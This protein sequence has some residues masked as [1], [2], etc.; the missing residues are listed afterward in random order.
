M[1]DN[2]EPDLSIRLLLKV[3]DQ[4]YDKKSWHGTTLRGSLRNVNIREALWRP[5]AKHHNIW[6]IVRHAAYWKFAVWRKISGSA[7]AKFP[8]EGSDWVESET[9]PD[10]KTWKKDLQLL[11]Q[12]HIR[13]HETVE[14]LDPGQLYQKPA[15]SKSYLADLI[16]GIAAH[17]LYHAGQVQLLKRLKRGGKVKS[18]K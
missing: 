3:I 17:D 2:P 10:E 4:A 12:Y 18:K 11:R 1:D 8:Y 5:S 15:G 16:V 6:E 13:L 14:A 9:G 7:S